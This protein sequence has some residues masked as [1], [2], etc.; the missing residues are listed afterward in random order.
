MSDGQSNN[1]VEV[2]PDAAWADLT[3]SDEALLVDCR[4]LFEWDTIGVPDLSDTGGEAH[5]IEWRQGPA[6]TVNPEFKSQLQAAIGDRQPKRI[7]FMCRSGQ[8]SRE[9]ATYYQASLSSSGP[10]CACINVAEGFEGSPDGNGMR[11]QI[12]GWQARGLPWFK[13]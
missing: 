5:L 9:A 3:E 1:I 2:T 8:R 4:T 13:R 12:N 7:Y 11:G 10:S 6:M